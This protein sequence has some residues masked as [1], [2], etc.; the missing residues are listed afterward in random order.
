[1][2][3][4]AAAALEAVVF[5][6]PPARHFYDNYRLDAARARVLKLRRDFQHNIGVINAGSMKGLDETDFN[7]LRGMFL[8][9]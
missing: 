3:L 7:F 5:A 8:P 9:S 2:P 6:E 4:Y 1:M